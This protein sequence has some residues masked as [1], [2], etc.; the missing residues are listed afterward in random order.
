[1][2][3]GAPV[4][5]AVE[6]APHDLGLRVRVEGVLDAGRGGAAEV[7]ARRG[8][9]VREVPHEGDRVLRRQAR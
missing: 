5:I 1:M 6:R 4:G 8:R 7:G 2:H 9:A 3:G